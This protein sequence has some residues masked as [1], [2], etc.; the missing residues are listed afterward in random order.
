MGLT[1]RKG[2]RP[3]CG[4]IVEMTVRGVQ[5]E[6][7]NLLPSD[8]KDSRVIARQDAHRSQLRV[9]DREWRSRP[10]VVVLEQGPRILANFIVR[11][12]EEVVLDEVVPARPQGAP[13]ELAR[14]ASVD[15]VIA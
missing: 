12:R 10:L 9:R 13:G 3:R 5:T 2:Q 8:G 14:S 1:W 15:I 11:V 6:N 7:S 4:F